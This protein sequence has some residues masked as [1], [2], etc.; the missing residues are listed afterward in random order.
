MSDETR[1]DEEVLASPAPLRLVARLFD[2]TQGLRALLAICVFGS[3]CTAGLQ[4]WLPLILRQAVDRFM[5][6]GGLPLAQRTQ[7]VTSLAWTYAAVLIGYMG[8][9]TLVTLGLSYVG[10]RV[11]ARVRSDMFRHLH[12]LPIGWYDKNPVGRVVTR[13]AND[14]DALCDIFS[15]VI[16]AVVGDIILLVGIV[17]TIFR[18]N[19]SVALLVT[20]LL[21]LLALLTAWFR[22]Q[23]QRLYRRIR[24]LLARINA[25]FQESVQG[26]AVIKSFNAEAR[27][28]AHFAE[29]NQAHYQA[30]MAMVYVFAIFRPLV[31]AAA[32]IGTALLL[33]RG[34]HQ[35]LE[36]VL[37]L[38]T[39][40]A[41]LSYVKMLFAPID[42]MAEKLNVFQQALIAC[43]RIYRILDTPA[44]AVGH[45]ATPAAQGHIV[46]EHVS[47]A[48]E[49][50]KPV[51]HDVSFEIKPGETVA[52]VGPT[53]S[54]KTTIGGLL[55]GFYRLEGKGE[56]R[57]LVDGVPI[58]AWHP[59]ALR[60]RIGLV[61]QDLFLF[62]QDLRHNVALFSDPPEARLTAA[63]E[64][65]QSSRIIARLPQ[66]LAHRIGERGAS[67]SQGERQLLSFARALVLDPP[68]LLLDE[69]TASVDS[70][71]EKA[72]QD[73]LRVILEGRTAL[74][75][76]HRLST[77]QEADRI[78]VLKKGRIVEQGKHADLLALD[79]LYAHLFRSQQ[80]EASVS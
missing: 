75:V 31:G 9:A 35:V 8:I 72:I 45:A 6:S 10:Q 58:E 38:G 29:M 79:G 68:I 33:W 61:Q 12:R 15:S 13:L 67:L 59:D 73:A 71:T 23:S 2:W 53:G 62:R 80:L 52:L 26:L 16:A 70:V 32:P 4:I 7:G 30:E 55:L 47:F 18:L 56:G 74:V 40:V 36:H 51:L 37:T 54:G 77:V 64:A 43:E 3:L 20:L 25:F 46:F 27:M 76:A 14:T 44:E 60:Q 21:P 69:A 41:F 78:L 50:D 28:S 49:P 66:G 19:A 63:L 1:M 57:I 34:G 24:S 11:V 42:E 5:T 65:S 48:Y 17:L 39:L 22:Q